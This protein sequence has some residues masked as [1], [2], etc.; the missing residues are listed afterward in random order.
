MFTAPL[1]NHESIAQKIHLLVG[2]VAV[3]KVG[4]AT[5]TEMKEKKARVEDALN[6]NGRLWKRRSFP[7]A[8]DI[9][10]WGCNSQSQ[11]D[12]TK[13]PICKTGAFSFG[14]RVWKCGGRDGKNKEGLESGGDL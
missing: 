1:G 11:V 5:E 13:A 10:A 6:A 12:S 4:V 8:A 14:R 2:G 7:V 9:P 3:F